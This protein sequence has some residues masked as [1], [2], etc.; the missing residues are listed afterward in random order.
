MIDSELL[1]QEVP[2]SKKIYFGKDVDIAIATFLRSDSEIEKNRI[3]SKTI[4]P[5]FEQLVRNIIFNSIK[6]GTPY[7]CDDSYE[8][9]KSETITFLYTKL[10]TFDPN[11]GRA[12]SYFNVCARNYIL[13]SSQESYKR[14]NQHV[15]LDK[16]DSERDTLLEESYEHQKT[17]FHT[18]YW[19]WVK[20][21]SENIY[22][23]YHN[24]RDRRIADAILNILKRSQYFDI[25]YKKFLYLLIREQLGGDI[26]TTYI[27]TVMKELRDNFALKYKEYIKL[28]ERERD[29]IQTQR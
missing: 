10:T 26:P 1:L 8:D 15:G 27:T 3:F 17:L 4:Y 24:D 5:A 19:K 20:Y 13:A 2:R 25:Y 11:R 6:K 16:V 29:I 12:F 18:F 9:L 14:R 23:L 7:Y 22:I 21:C 28:H